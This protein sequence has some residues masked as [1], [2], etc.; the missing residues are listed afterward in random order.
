[1]CVCTC[2]YVC[3]WMCVWM[4]V[5][6]CVCVCECEWVYILVG[7][8]VLRGGFVTEGLYTTT[9][10][11]LHYAHNKMTDI[12]HGQYVIQIWYE[13]VSIRMHQSMKT[14]TRST[15]ASTESENASAELA[16]VFMGAWQVN[17]SCWILAFQPIMGADLVK[18]GP[19]LWVLL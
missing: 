3:V 10:E 18:R 11:T 4:C 9:T 13:W 17:C 15:A 16:L 6:V 14:H 7:R 19:P 1:M 2:V 8:T 5:C 12:L